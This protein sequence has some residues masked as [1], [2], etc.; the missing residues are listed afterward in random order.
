MISVLDYRVISVWKRNPDFS[1]DHA[2]IL[3]EK[4]RI[5]RPLAGKDV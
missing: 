5:S 4:S 2:L 1:R 3:T